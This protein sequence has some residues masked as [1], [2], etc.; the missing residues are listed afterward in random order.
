MLYVL[1]PCIRIYY[2]RTYSTSDSSYL[3]KIICEEFF[4]TCRLHFTITCIILLFAGLELYHKIHYTSHSPL[5]PARFP[6]IPLL[7]LLLLLPQLQWDCINPSKQSKKKYK[8]SGTVFLESV[9][10]SCSTHTV[11]HSKVE[12]LVPIIIMLMLSSLRI[13]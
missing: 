5:P 11:G 2:L 6:L 12:T 1:Y 10:V 8:N 13:S 4:T 9:R 7:L 3:N